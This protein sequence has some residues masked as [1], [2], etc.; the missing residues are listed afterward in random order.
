[1]ACQSKK[2]T[3]KASMHQQSK[4]APTKQV[5]TNTA[6]HAAWIEAA[7]AAVPVHANVRIINEFIKKFFLLFV[8]SRESAKFAYV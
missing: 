6:A 4:Y 2:C 8:I 7:Q 1:A 5:C 3:N